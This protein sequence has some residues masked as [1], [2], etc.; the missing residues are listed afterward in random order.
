MKQFPTSVIP[1]RAKREPGISP[2]N[3]E[4]PDRSAFRGPSGMTTI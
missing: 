3:L 2:Y 4:I 1:G